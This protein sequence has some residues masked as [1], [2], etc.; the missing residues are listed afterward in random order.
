MH[1]VIFIC[2]Y[3]LQYKCLAGEDDVSIY[4]SLASCG[5]RSRLPVRVCASEAPMT[6][7]SRDLRL[8][9]W[10][11]LHPCAHADCIPKKG[12]YKQ[13][14]IISAHSMNTIESTEFSKY[15]IVRYT[16]N[17]SELRAAHGNKVSEFLLWIKWLRSKHAR[18]NS[19]WHMPFDLCS[20]KNA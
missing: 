13:R 14:F 3:Y 8:E 15:I 11:P 9:G 4:N 12:Q 2:F 16:L 19:Q 18:S 6:S 5:M 17:P 1:I 7:A 10:T 20:N